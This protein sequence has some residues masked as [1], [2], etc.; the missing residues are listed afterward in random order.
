MLARMLKVRNTIFF[1]RYFSLVFHQLLKEVLEVYR[2][3][4]AQLTKPEDVIT[5]SEQ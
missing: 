4:K 5:D 2:F 3:Q 1:N